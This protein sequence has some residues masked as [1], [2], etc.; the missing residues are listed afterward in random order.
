MKMFRTATWGKRITGFEIIKETAKQV[1]YQNEGGHE[2]RE[3]KL[4][5]HNSWHPT[6]GEAQE[7]LIIKHLAKVNGAERRLEREQEE[8]KEITELQP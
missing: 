4:S 2:R 8:L 3:A 1:T 5:D 6:W 7:F